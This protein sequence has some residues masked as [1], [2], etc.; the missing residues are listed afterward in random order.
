MNATYD[1]HDGSVA[2]GTL[3]CAPCL[4]LALSGE[5]VQK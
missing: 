3:N 5:G 4:A 2:L 1:L